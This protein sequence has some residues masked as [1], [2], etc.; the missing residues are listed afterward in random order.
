MMHGNWTIKEKKKQLTKKET[1]YESIIFKCKTTCL[2]SNNWS[3]SL[4]ILY[5]IWV[6]YECESWAIKKAK[7]QRIDTFELWGAEEDSWE[8]PE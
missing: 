5:T 6:L 1:C 8:F 3:I 7:H 2:F 4:V